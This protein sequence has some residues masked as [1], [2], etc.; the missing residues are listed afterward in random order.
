MKRLR[1]L[2]VAL[3]IG[4]LGCSTPAPGPS[5][6]TSAEPAGHGAAVLVGAG[7][8]GDC[9]QPGSDLTARLLDRL[10]G[11]V[12]TTGDNA[13]P[14][15][16]PEDFRNCYEP[17]WGRHRHRTR[18]SAGNH[19]YE[20][21]PGASAYFSYFGPQAGLPGLGYYSY[22]LGAW[23]VIALNSE[24]PAH[25]NSPQ[26]EWLRNELA[27]STRRCTVAYWHRP[28]FSSGMYGDDV[29]MAD[30]WRM[31]YEHR[32]D[33]V[34]TGHEHSYERLTALDGEGRTDPARGIRSFVVGTG[35]TALR[36]HRHPRPGSE[37]RGVAWGVLALTLDDG[38]YEWEFLPVDGATFRDIGAGQ[39]H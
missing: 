37:S 2:A 34:I 3:S 35:G 7:D 21:S 33:V 10:P 36:S 30:V 25:G 1:L 17:T 27:A 14:S 32:V 39:C 19:E 5:P 29:T 8:I 26:L 13:Y 31:L 38:R 23:H 6:L 9:T 28:R 22:T 20:G 16:R 18:P 24:I 4:T 11:T 12:F 15:G